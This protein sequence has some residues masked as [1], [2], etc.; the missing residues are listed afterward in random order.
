MKQEYTCISL[1]NSTVWLFEAV[2]GT[3]GLNL[4]YAAIP[5][6]NNCFIIQLSQGLSE[7]RS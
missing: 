4:Y 2:N 7:R 5:P 3:E 1:K 6:K